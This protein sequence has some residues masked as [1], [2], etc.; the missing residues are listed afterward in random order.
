MSVHLTCFKLLLNTFLSR[1]H[2]N[3]LPLLG[4]PRFSSHLSK[5][6]SVTDIPPVKSGRD[7]AML[8]KGREILEEMIL[9]GDYAHVILEE[10]VESFIVG[11]LVMSIV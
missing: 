7:E 6:Y 9:N 8:S 4:T 5:L 2:R 10:R 11:S 3:Q 1:A